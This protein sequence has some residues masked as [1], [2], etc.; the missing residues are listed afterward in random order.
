MSSPKKPLHHH[1]VDYFLPHSRNGHRPHI[2]SVTSVAVLAIMIVVFEA[3]YIFQTKIVFF[4]TDFLASVLPS[5]L[6][7]LTNVA[8][9]ENGLPSVT[10]NA[11]LD[12][13]AQASAE[14][15]AAKGYFSHK[16]PDG[17]EPW[18]WL[19][20]AG[21]KYSYA[22]QNL[23]VNFTDS[24]NVQ[25]AWLASPT[26]KENIMKPQYTEVG[27]GT[28]NGY[29]QGYETTFVVEFF[30]TPAVVAA[31]KPAAPAKPVAVVTKPVPVA[32]TSSVLGTGIQQASSSA[33]TE[34]TPTAA[35]ESPSEAPAPEVKKVDT[36]LAS[37]FSTLET[38]LTIL[39]GIVASAFGFAVLMRGKLQHPSVV[40]AGSFLILLISATI[41]GS[42]MLSGPVILSDNSQMASIEAAF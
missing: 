12:A 11:V 9:A 17:K 16:T 7:D 4:T 22:G 8:R 2:F 3:G 39:L 15:M 13:A 25:T 23:A 24:E 20:Q 27:F 35:V 18:Y 38:I 1:V 40:Y 21:Y 29:Y 41:L 30:A 26:H 6:T 19:D 28:A 34:V 31:T 10:R 33:D 5:V 14:D 42:V 36:L 37:P 32:A